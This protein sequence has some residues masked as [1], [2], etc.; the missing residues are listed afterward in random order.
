MKYSRINVMIHIFCSMNS[1]CFSSKKTGY[2]KKKKYNNCIVEK[3]FWYTK[4]QDK[5]ENYNI[6]SNFK[7]VLFYIYIYMQ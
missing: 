5:L 4:K 7:G 6:T 3:M 1:G 2:K